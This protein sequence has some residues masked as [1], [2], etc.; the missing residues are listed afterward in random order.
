MIQLSNYPLWLI[1]LASVA[2]MW[3][4]SDFGRRLGRPGAERE[5]GNLGTLEAAIFGL[6]ALMISFTFAMALTRY[7]A[8][9]GAVL[10]EANAIGTTALRARLLAPPLDSESL[11]LLQTYTQIRLDAAQRVL[12]DVEMNAAIERSNAIQE[13]LWQI[14]KQELA[15]DTDK[16]TA[17]LFILALNEMIDDQETR[18]TAIRNRVPNIVLLAL[19]GIGLFALGIGGYADGLDNRRPRFPVYATAVLVVGVVLLIQDLDRPTGAIQV[20]T[21]PM[22][23]TAASLAKYIDQK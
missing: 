3:L 15:Q 6:L 10:N 16:V 19:Y 18:L 17:G 13:K 1:F 22:R 14:A 12:P 5:S 7:D 8:R 4:A 2:A 11:K 20:S 21:Q 9:R 23:D